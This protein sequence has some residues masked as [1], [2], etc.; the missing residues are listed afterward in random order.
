MQQSL[1]MAKSFLDM[2]DDGYDDHIL[3]DLI[4]DGKKPAKASSPRK[5]ENTTTAQ[6]QKPTRA[7]KKSFLRNIEQNIGESS[8]KRVPPTSPKSPA[9]KTV[10]RKSFL[11]TIEE[12][13]DQSAFDDLIPDRQWAKREKADFPDNGALERKFGSLVTPAVLARVRAIAKAKGVS[14]QDV[15]Q[16]AIELYL[17]SET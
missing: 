10:K 15:I 1:F 2:L 3:S 7:R 5:S 14:V 4:P 16:R 17:R 13:Y 11:E 9:R 12:A 6:T 8:P